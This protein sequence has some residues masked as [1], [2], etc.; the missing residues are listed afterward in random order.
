MSQIPDRHVCPQL[1]VLGFATRGPFGPT[2]REMS[3]EKP[4]FNGVE[5]DAYEQ[6]PS[7]ASVVASSNPITKPIV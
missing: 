6:D 2:A 7:T 1:F 3:G 4:G 5:A